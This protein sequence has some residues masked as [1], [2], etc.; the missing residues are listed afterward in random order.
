[1]RDINRIEPFIKKFQKMWESTPDL[2]FGQLICIIAGQLKQKDIF[3]PEEKEWEIAIN[4][5]L[6]RYKQSNQSII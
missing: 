6:E 4:K 1:M 5:V 3:F 2:R